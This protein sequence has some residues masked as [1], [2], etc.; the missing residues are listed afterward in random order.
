MPEIS[1]QD[2]PIVGRSMSLLVL[3]SLVLL[4][5]TVAWSLY[6]EFY[7]LRPWLSY[8]NRF[9]GAYS[10]YLEKQIAARRTAE[11]TLQATPDYQHLNTDRK[12]VV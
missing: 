7:G 11:Q 1:P 8:Q 9:R 3:I 12:S 10:A 5:G 6:D 2:D 4:L